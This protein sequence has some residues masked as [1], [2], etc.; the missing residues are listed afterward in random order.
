MVIFIGNLSARD[1]FIAENEEAII[2]SYKKIVAEKGI[3]GGGA[4]QQAISELWAGADEAF[5][6]K[7]AKD[8]SD[9]TELWVIVLSLPT[10]YSDYYILRNQMEFPGLM[11]RALND[12]CQ[13]Q[14]LGS[15]VMMLAYAFRDSNDDIDSGMQVV[16]LPRFLA[17]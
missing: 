17:N 1:L 13:C 3:P 8:M 14:A 9:N 16:S 11:A 4:R 6:Q 2:E 5:W 7:K 12:I 10:C 15:S